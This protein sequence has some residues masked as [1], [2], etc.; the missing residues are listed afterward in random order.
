MDNGRTQKNAQVDSA[1]G[2]TSG[3]RVKALIRNDILAGAIRSGERVKIA[4]LAKRYGTSQ[5]PVR[6]ALYQLEGEGLVET[7]AHRGAMIR[8]VDA[9]FIYDMY[10]I[11]RALETMLLTHAVGAFRADALRRLENARD[12]YKRAAAGSD[13][14][15]MLRCNSAFHG[16]INLAADNQEAVRILNRGWDLIFALRLRFG[17]GESRAAQIIEEHDALVAAIARGDLEKAIVI[18]DQ[19]CRSARDDLLAQLA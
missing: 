1:L 18:S 16:L 6:E 5:M 2:K 10:E 9:K 17:F 11:R 8:T 19:H 14:S 4:D 13:S 15:E 12:D 3:G 7:S